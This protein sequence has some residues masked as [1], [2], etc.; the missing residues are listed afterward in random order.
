MFVLTSPDMTYGEIFSSRRHP[1]VLTMTNRYNLD[2]RIRILISHVSHKILRHRELTQ[3]EPF[4]HAE[5]FP[6]GRALLCSR[7]TM[8]DFW[9]QYELR[10]ERSRQEV[11]LDSQPYKNGMIPPIDPILT[12]LPLAAMMKGWKLRTMRIGPNKLISN[13]RCTATTSVSIAVMV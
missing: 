13:M 6:N 2:T 3:K 5:Y 9:T 4:P 1:G 11:E 10:A 7:C 12:I 8:L